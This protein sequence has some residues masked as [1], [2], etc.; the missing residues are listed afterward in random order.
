M[1]QVTAEPGNKCLHVVLKTDAVTAFL[2]LDVP[3]IPGHFSQNGFLL[4]T[5]EIEVKFYSYHP[6]GIAVFKNAL[7]IKALQHVNVH[8]N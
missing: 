4:V 2:W 8:K 7:Q 1:I 5:S 3:N 6:V